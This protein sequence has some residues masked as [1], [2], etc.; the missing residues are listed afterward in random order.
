MLLEFTTANN[1]SFRDRVT[2]SLL[3]SRDD[4]LEDENVGTSSEYR[5]VKAAAIYGPNGSGKSN[6]LN[7]LSRMR[8]WVLNSSKDSQQGEQ[9][10]VS[11]FRLNTVTETGASLFEVVF[12]V[13]P[14]KYRYGFQ[15][16]T[17]EVLNEWLLVQAQ[18]IRETTLFV[19]E[20]GQI[21]P[22][23]EF[24]EGNGLEVRT[25]PNAL[26]LSVVA[27]FNGTIAG[28]IVAWFE[29]IR[30]MSGLQEGMPNRF[31]VEALGNP[32]N[33]AII[34]EMVRHA[35]VGI[36]DIQERPADPAQLRLAFPPDMP[37]PVR[38]RLLEDMRRPELKT[39]HRKFDGDRRTEEMVEFDLGRDESAG[40][41]KFI[42]LLGPFLS[43]LGRGSLLVVDEF[44][45]R[46]HPKLSRALLSLFNS[47][48]N[49]KN[50][51]IIFASHDPGLLNPRYLR[52]DQVWFVEKDES[53]ASALYPLSDFS[54]R[55][56]AL[57]EKE[58]LAGEFGAVPHIGD[59]QEILLR[60]PKE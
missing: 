21:K 12:L 17:T 10:P 27:Q 18:S 4:S 9:I 23:S 25:R 31:I 14:Q 7:A 2:L 29:G 32:A 50:A 36:E 41:K 30:I 37:E 26:F 51:Q 59:L 38:E 13:G 22:G 1:R 48:V 53:G 24:R 3:A 35:D 57:F 42:Q 8:K 44:E 28:E 34:R 15:A 16:T 56:G 40:T 43:S 33:R 11:P 49:Q 52:R 55:K 46:L 19:R 39:L 47:I 54:V 45:A 60:A 20:N 58:Y 5:T 6:L